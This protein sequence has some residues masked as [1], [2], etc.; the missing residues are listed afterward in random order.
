[1]TTQAERISHRERHGIAWAIRDMIL[2]ASRDET[3]SAAAAAMLATVRDQAS[4]AARKQITARGFAAFTTVLPDSDRQ[5]I[6]EALR[7]AS[8]RM[9]DQVI[10]EIGAQQAG[11]RGRGASGRFALARTTRSRLAPLYGLPRP[12]F[13][14][15]HG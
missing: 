13:E 4:G 7:S 5:A 6:F 2:T 11:N 8:E 1:M 12:I 3:P 15:P 9:A 14:R 10:E